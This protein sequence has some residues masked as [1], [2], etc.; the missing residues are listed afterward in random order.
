MGHRFQSDEFSQRNMA[1][2]SQSADSAIT[3]GVAEDDYR[4]QMGA[5]E[6]YVWIDADNHH[7]PMTAYDVRGMYQNM[8]RWKQSHI[9][10]ARALKDMD[11]IPGDYAADSHWTFVPPSEIPA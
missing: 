7:V 3:R 11:P 9:F 4:W 5:T 1:D 8:M 6:D 10:S 2:A